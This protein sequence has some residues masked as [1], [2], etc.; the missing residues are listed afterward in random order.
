MDVVRRVINESIRVYGTN[1]LVFR[2]DDPTRSTRPSR[3]D[4]TSYGP[5]TNITQVREARIPRKPSPLCFVL[6]PLTDSAVDCSDSAPRLDCSH[7][8]ESIPEQLTAVSTRDVAS[9]LSAW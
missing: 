5:T 9:T 4:Y 3:V 6:T 2:R 8:A 7:S 1:L